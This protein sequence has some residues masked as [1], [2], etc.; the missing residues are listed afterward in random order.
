[1][2]NRDAVQTAAALPP[3]PRGQ[4]QRHAGHMDQGHG[5]G[6]HGKRREQGVARDCSEAE[7]HTGDA[8]IGGQRSLERG[9]EMSQTGRTTRA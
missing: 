9:S 3:L 4:A 8:D 1:L 7:S 6:R 2:L 5:G